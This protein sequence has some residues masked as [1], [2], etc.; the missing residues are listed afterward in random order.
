MIL[1]LDIGNSN[2]VIAILEIDKKLAQWRLETDKNKTYEK[3]E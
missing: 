1:V 3:Y 2:I